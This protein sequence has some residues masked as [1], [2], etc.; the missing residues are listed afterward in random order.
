MVD[1]ILLSFMLA[2][3]ALGFWLGSKYRSPKALW[4]ALKE[5]IK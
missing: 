1:L 4:K 2:V 5:Q 3:F